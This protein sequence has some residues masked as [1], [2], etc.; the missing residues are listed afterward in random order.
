MTTPNPQTIDLNFSLVGKVAIV[1]G[2]ASGIGSAI[3]DAFTAKGATVVVLD[4]ALQAAQRKVDEGKAVAALGCDVTSEES[5]STAVDQVA[6]RFGRI[7]IVVNSAGVV[8]LDAAEDLGTDAWNVTMA[9][10]LRGAFL[11]SQRAGRVMLAQGSGK[12]ISLAS[13]AGTVALPSH[14]AYCASKSGLLG[15][16]RVLA[17]E[18]GGRGVTANT[19]SPTVVLTDLGRA[20]WDNPQGEALKQQI[21]A[22]RFALPEEIAAAAVFLASDGANMINGV[23]LLV[24]GG[25]TIR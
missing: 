12:V 9:V 25:Y 6:A 11:V 7:D 4:R 19:I 22:N 24:D 18:W 17:L 8:L 14:A 5:V 20:A 21:P 10:N 1:T 16:T 23:D 15:L 3:V 13:Q 2:G